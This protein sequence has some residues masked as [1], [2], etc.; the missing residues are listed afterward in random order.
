[1]GR[2]D[3]G[4][5]RLLSSDIS[6]PCEWGV[7]PDYAKASSGNALTLLPAPRLRR[8]VPNDRFGRVREYTGIVEICCASFRP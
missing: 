4:L 2:G 6:F 7:L 3:P 8:P 1:M 5:L